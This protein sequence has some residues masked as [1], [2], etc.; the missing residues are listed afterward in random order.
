M[1]AAGS[2]INLLQ[3]FRSHEG[4]RATEGHSAL[5]LSGTEGRL[6]LHRLLLASGKGRAFYSL[7]CGS[8]WDLGICPLQSCCHAEV[9]Q[10]NAAVI[11]NKEIGCL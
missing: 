2:P 11:I 10:Q 9:C 6:C 5:I 3:N 7:C 4:R 1:M 8:C